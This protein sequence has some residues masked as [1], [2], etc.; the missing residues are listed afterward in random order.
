MTVRT[1]GGNYNAELALEL[2][3]GGG[4]CTLLV[5]ELEWGSPRPPRGES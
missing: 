4:A 2:W 3:P 5:V 1:V